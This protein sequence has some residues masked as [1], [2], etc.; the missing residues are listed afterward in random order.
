LEKLGELY[1]FKLDKKNMK[2]LIVKYGNYA[3]GTIG[4]LG[5][6]TIEDLNDINNQ[7]EYVLRPKYN[8]KCWNELLN[9]RINEI[10]I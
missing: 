1:I 4:K 9:F 6:I 2:S 8:N 10:V 5:K 7:K 3:H